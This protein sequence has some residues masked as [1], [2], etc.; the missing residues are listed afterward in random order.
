MAKKKRYRNTFWAEVEDIALQQIDDFMQ[1]IANQLH[2][3]LNLPDRAGKP[4][5]NRG[6]IIDIEYEEIK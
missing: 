3:K 2:K 4:P 1:D 5:T 6:K